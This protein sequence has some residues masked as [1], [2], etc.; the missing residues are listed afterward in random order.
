VPVLI[1]LLRDADPDVGADAAYALAR[2]G[3][4]ARAAVPALLDT[5]RR[6]D[7]GGGR[8]REAAADALGRI[9]P[10]AAGNAGVPVRAGGEQPP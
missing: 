6:K 10:E 8:L 3:P 5:L 4:E 2:I 1:E 7:P 9:D